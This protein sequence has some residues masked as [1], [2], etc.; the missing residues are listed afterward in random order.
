MHRHPAAVDG[1]RAVR[2]QGTHLRSAPLLRVVAQHADLWNVAG[3]DIDDAAARS[4]LLDRV[5]AEIGRDPASLA[6]SIHLPVSYDR[7]PATRDAIGRAID[8][9]FEHTRARA[10][11]AVSRRCRTV[12]RRRARRAGLRPARRR[13]HAD[14]AAPVVDRRSARSPEGQLM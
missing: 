12:G 13:G 1:G 3:G 11:G 14:H 5:C 4:A 10:A 7:P 9:G 2:L 8:A 6:R